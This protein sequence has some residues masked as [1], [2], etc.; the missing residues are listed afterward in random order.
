M[1]PLHWFL[2]F[3]DPDLL[4]TRLIESVFYLH[5]QPPLLNLFTGLVLKAFP[6]SYPAVF[7]GVFA[8]LGLG[9]YTLTF[10]LQ[11]RLGVA[12]WLAFGLSTLFAIS[13]AF[14]FY[15]HWY[16][17]TLPCALLVTG[18][19]YCLS[20]YLDGRRWAWLAGFFVVLA[21]LCAT[22][23]LFHLV[24]FLGAGGALFVVVKGSRRQVLVCAAVPF[25]LLLSLYVKNWVVFGQFG[26]SSFMGRNLWIMAVGNMNHEQRE[27]LVES[28]ALSEVSLIE[29]WN[30]VRRYPEALQDV[31]AYPDVPALREVE[32]RNG[33]HNFN[34]AANLA[35][36]EAYKRDA[37]YAMRHHPKAFISSLRYPWYGY[38][39]A[40]YGMRGETGE[41]L[42]GWKRA[43]ERTAFLELPEAWTANWRTARY[44]GAPPYLTLLI[45]LPASLLFGV[46]WTVRRWREGDQSEA[47]LAGYL[48][49]CIVFVAIIGTTFDFAETNRYRFMTDALYLALFGTFLQTVVV[50]PVTR[51]IRAQGH[52]AVARGTAPAK[53]EPSMAASRGE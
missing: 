21:V 19:A 5:I 41:R 26:L 18:S 16:F 2:H 28:G 14:L 15:E 25:V 23:S 42:S 4:Q 27:A 11:R 38:F 6:E 1:T 43:F 47:T 49:Y 31:E 40:H 13:P 50:T 37:V 20:R 46:Y 34:H 39:Q 10:A 24:F 35:V 12:A 32:K 22:R 52:S 9:L 8:A 36:S 30:D 17:Y 53:P 3:L 33:A 51:R 45:V 29:R 7:Q 48:L 44:F